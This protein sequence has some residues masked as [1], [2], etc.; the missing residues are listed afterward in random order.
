M[1]EKVSLSWPG[2][3]RDAKKGEKSHPGDLNPSRRFRAVT[4][5]RFKS[6][7]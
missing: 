2:D 7:N 5:R 3:A 1:D 4:Q 6:Q